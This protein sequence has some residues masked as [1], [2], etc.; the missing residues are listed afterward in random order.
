MV[1]SLS[2]NRRFSDRSAWA[3]SILGML[4]REIGRDEREVSTRAMVGIR[5]VDPPKMTPPSTLCKTFDRRGKPADKL[6]Y[7]VLA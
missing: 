6:L 7:G 5:T 4:V 2:F 3:Q 1:S